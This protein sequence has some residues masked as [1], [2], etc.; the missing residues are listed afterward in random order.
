V[1]HSYDVGD[2]VMVTVTFRN[3]AGALADPSVINVIASHPDGSVVTEV[4]P[5]NVHKDSTGVFHCEVVLDAPGKW[6][7]RGQ[8]TGAVTAAEEVGFVVA[9]QRAGGA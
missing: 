3:A 1:A 5:T 8:G 7:V 9:A 4:Y 2:V 6:W